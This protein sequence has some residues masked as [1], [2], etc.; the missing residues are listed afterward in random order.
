MWKFKVLTQ[1]TYYFLG[2]KFLF[3]KLNESTDI[4]NDSIYT[5]PAFTISHWFRH[6]S[7]NPD[8]GPVSLYKGPFA[9]FCEV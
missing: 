5:I 8:L 1:F 6:M 4:D 9:R 3:V 7:L 2:T